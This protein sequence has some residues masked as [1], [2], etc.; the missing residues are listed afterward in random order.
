MPRRSGGPRAASVPPGVGVVRALDWNHRAV[1]CVAFDPGL[2]K[3][4]GGCLDGTV[5]LWDTIEGKLLRTFEWRRSPFEWQRSEV[6]S[7]AF[8][9]A[10]RLLASGSANGNVHLWDTESGELLHACP[11]QSGS[12]ASV[13]FHPTGSLLA[14]GADDGTVNLWDVANGKLLRTFRGPRAEVVGVAFDSAGRTLAR[15]STDG[16]VI[17]WDTTNGAL[18]RLFERHRSP[19]CS[20]GFE[21]SGHMLAVGSLDNTV[22]LWDVPNSKLRRILEGHRGS[23]VALSFHRRRPLLATMGWDDTIRVW[24]SETWDVVAVIQRHARYRFRGLSFHPSLPRL[25]VAGARLH[26]YELDLDV[27]LGE[28]QPTEAPRSVHY[29]NAKVVLVGD[30][31]VGKTGLSLVLGGRPYQATDSTAGRQVWALDTA[32][33][34]LPGD[35]RRARETLLW[36]LAGQ[37]GYRVIHQLHL[38]EVA[39]ALVVFDARSETDPL[40]GVVHW[41]RALRAAHQRQGDEAV[42]L[43]KFLVSAR[44]DRGGVPVSKERLD[45]LVKEFDFAGYFATSAKEGWRIG[46]L[47]AA[48]ESAIP[49]DELPTVTSSALF[50]TIKSYLIE[51]KETGRLLAPAGQLFEDFVRQG[52]EVIAEEDD[53]RADFDVCI[54]RLENRDLIRRLSFG[55]YVLLQPELLDAYASALVI[56]AKGEPDGLGSIAEERALSGQFHVPEDERIGDRKQEQLLLHSTVEELVRFDLAL[57]E[58]AA[59]GRYLVF[60]SQFNRD[61]AEAPDPPGKAVAVTFEGPTQSIYATLAVRLGHSQL[62]ET[63]RTEMWRNAVIFTA[64]AGGRCGIYLQEFSEGRGR[65]L[66]FFDAAT[67]ETR[68]HFEEYVLAHVNRRALYGTVQLLRLF[69]CGNCG[70]PVPD[71]YV[72][73]LREQRKDLFSCPCGGAVAIV[74]PK[75]RLARRYPSLV[76]SMDLAADH[77]RDFEAFVLSANAETHSSR[78]VE[79]AGDERVTLAIVFTDVVDSTALGERMRDERMYEVRQIHFTQSRE[80][81]AQYKGHEIRTIGD[82]V[83][84]AFRSVAAALDYARGL[85]A[86]PGMPELRLR[87]GIHIGPLQIEEGDVFGRTVNFAARVVGAIKGAGIWLSEQAKADIDALGARRH[88]QLQWQRHEK[89]ELKGFAGAFTLWSV[90][91]A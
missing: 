36:D 67:E 79:W 88:E 41:E 39:V 74:D 70:T 48:I 75:E 49:W 20:V 34:Q 4:A 27:L 23:V 50:A 6:A 83:M 32:E 80:L 13:A 42:P 89:I 43:T 65:L 10:G 17:L 46:E 68:F 52:L 54:G 57:R 9:P 22:R 60:P 29:V 87:A 1:K 66:L 90:D 51:V 31:G 30:T 25:A 53:L 61:Y 33:E 19:V 40:A 15:G 11:G 73:L 86:D 2:G 7:V 47:R 63:A 71:A 84:A 14:S 69:V 38:S 59:D 24:N 44:A 55:D 26:V 45:A 12:V 76:E 58:S 81:I 3:L 72:E 77:H 5:S 82:S 18:P 16:T 64:R 21:P 85:C 8:D 56:A 35:R 28:R 91:H 62:F 37:P 78:F